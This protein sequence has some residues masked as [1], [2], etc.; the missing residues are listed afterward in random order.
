MEVVLIPETLF[1]V[2]RCWFISLCTESPLPIF[3]VA[4][5]GDVVELASSLTLSCSA[6]L[7]VFI[8]ETMDDIVSVAVDA[9]ERSFSL[10]ELDAVESPSSRST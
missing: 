6:F 1:V 10:S 5:P 7:L 3:E 2:S 9:E 4:F 8:V